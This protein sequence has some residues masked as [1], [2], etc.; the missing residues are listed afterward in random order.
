[1]GF[2]DGLQTHS[3]CKQ[4]HPGLAEIPAPDGSQEVMSK[5][6]DSL[7]ISHFNN[8]WVQDGSSSHSDRWK[9]REI[10]SD[11]NDIASKLLM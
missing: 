7:G 10:T 2:I 5:V 8:S 4:W 6:W 9:S 3:S 11:G 1:M